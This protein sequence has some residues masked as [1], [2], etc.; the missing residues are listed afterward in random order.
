MTDEERRAYHRE[1]YEKNKDHARATQRAWY[2][3]NKEKVAATRK[4]Y[5][6]ANKAKYLERGKAWKQANPEK[7]KD[8]SRR[9]MRRCAGMLNPTAERR[10]GQCPICLRDGIE[11]HCDH[12]HSN[13]AIRGWLCRR[14]NPALG[15][16]NDSV[17]AMQRAIDYLM[18]NKDPSFTSGA[19]GPG[20]SK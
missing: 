3:A 16:L 4:K 13:G 12:D 1:W 11:L 14:C 20:R 7:H 15:L 6:E 5:Y 2:A 18:A 9:S 8:S 10:N 19:T 17:E